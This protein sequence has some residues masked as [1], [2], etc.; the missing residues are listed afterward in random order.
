MAAPMAEKVRMIRDWRDEL[1]EKYGDDS[2]EMSEEDWAEVNELVA[3]YERRHIDYVMSLYHNADLAAL[4]PLAL[5]DLIDELFEA[6]TDNREYALEKY[7]IGQPQ[8]M[9]LLSNLNRLSDITKPA[10][11]ARNIKKV[12]QDKA[13]RDLA[14][15][16][17]S[18]VADFLF[19]G[20]DLGNVR[21]FFLH[22][23][24]F[25]DKGN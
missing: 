1:R 12:R 23:D 22:P 14:E 21:S 24:H 4:D 20:S 2:V 17:N 16:E 9:D 11:H 15:L 8:I 13:L 7:D 25:K 5:Y 10:R 18:A 6:V 19:D 3:S